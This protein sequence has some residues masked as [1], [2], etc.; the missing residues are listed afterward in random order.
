MNSDS[1]FDAMIAALRAAYAAFNRGD[2]D[3]A[4]TPFDPQIEWTEPPE[5]PGGGTYHGRTGVKQYLTQSRGAWAEGRSDPERFIKAGDRV[6]V[7]VHARV[8]PKGSDEWHD[9]YLAD[10]YTFQ[11]GKAIH[12]RAFSNR[13]EALRWAGVEEL[14][15]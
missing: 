9:V 8:R 2:I 10:V 14:N 7:F 6:V 11:N 13:R 5:F 12:M 1:Q 15:P 4:L 3:A